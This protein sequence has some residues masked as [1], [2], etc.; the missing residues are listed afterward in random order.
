MLGTVRR[1]PWRAAL[2]AAGALCA[3][4]PAAPRA[5]EPSP[6]A[7]VDAFEKVSGAH[8]G[9]RR[10]GAKGV[11]ASGEFV[12]SGAGARLSTAPHLQQ[13][14]RAPVVARFSNGGGN[15]RAPDNAPGTRGLALAFEL[16]GGEGHEM[17]MISAPVFAAATAESLVRLLESRAPD[18]ATR[19]PPSAERI[20]AANAANP[21]WAPQ[22]TWVRETPP[23]ASYATAPY[24]GVNSFVFVDGAGAR[25]HARWTFEPVAGRAGLTPE[26]RQALGPD[27]LQNEL[28][29]RVA[30]APAE[31][32]VLL[33]LP[34]PEDPLT[35]ATAAW[36]ADREAVE[37]GR[38]R[39]TGVAPAGEKG[40]CDPVMFNPLILPKGI[41]PSDDPILHARPAPYAVSLSR[42]SQ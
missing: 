33:V 40:A 21:D 2:A 17:V 12:S 6:E 7:I 1:A 10:S 26:Q 13:G 19:A 35:D 39:V 18:P 27:F 23:A 36:P 37:V 14:A 3:M 20:A 15:P 31:W 38:L 22:L 42:R 28:R 24:F 5:Q 4:V 9:F 34:R 16:P 29:E 11:C 8:P 41:E 25:R 30:R 32:R